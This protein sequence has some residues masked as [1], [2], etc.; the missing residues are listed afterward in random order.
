MHEPC[1]P[2][3]VAHESVPHVGPAQPVQQRQTPS[4]PQSPWAWQLSGHVAT[5]QSSDVQP[6]SH[7]HTPSWQAP[8]PEQSLGQIFSLQSAP[9]QYRLH[10]HVPLRHVPWPLQPPAQM[11]RSHA[12][13]A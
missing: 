9:R 4:A 12:A 11:R 1:G 3:S 5:E 10:A 13:P 2:Q 7:A 6:A 8:R